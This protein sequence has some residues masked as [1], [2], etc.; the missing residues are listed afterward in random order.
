MTRTPVIVGVGQ[1]SEQLD[2]DRYL[3]LSPVDLAAAA[4]R[5]ALA[6]TGVSPGRVAE[7]IDTVA[8][9][10]QFEISLPGAPVLL[11]RSDNFPRSVA[12]RLGADPRRA[13]LEVV[14]GQAPQKLV[15]E[16]AREIA[17]GTT[18]VALVFGSEAISTAEHFAK[19]PEDRRP[20]WT[21]HAEGSLED[22]GPGLE[23]L[24]SMPLVV[25]GLYDTISQYALFENAR[26]ARLKLTRQEY[27]ESMGRLF[28][29]FTE[30]ASRNP[31]SAAPQR[32]GAAELVTPSARNR[33]IADPYTKFVVARE[34][35]NQAAAV[36]VMSTEKACEL[37][38]P[39]EKWVYPAGHADL[40]EREVLDRPDLSASPAT[41]AAIGHALEVAGVSPSEVTWFDL[42]SCYPIAV[43]VAA[44]ALGVERDLTLTGGLPFF[45]G[46]GNNYSMHGIAEVVERTRREPGSY[47]FVGAN[48]GLLS[49]YSAGVYTTTPTPWRADRSA[50]LQRAL[51]AGP[52]TEVTEKPDGPATIETWTVKHGRDGARTGIV[53]GRLDD[54]GRRF[55]ARAA[56]DEA[57]ALLE[58]EEPVG[59]RVVV[60]S[61]EDGNLFAV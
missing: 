18:E 36:L 10:R 48:G 5:E 22:R 52:G 7:V 38:I 42:Y 44:E 19:Q 31:H 45:G 50:E 1:A 28:E 53:V 12:G 61:G 4:A 41:A 34:K 39:E 58:T 6:D 32:R 20:D 16:L 57:L 13:I 21:E 24:I 17:A 8:G 2:D 25:H 30:V 54:D 15:T 23:G 60:R 27:A 55:V 37:G 49:K 59:A 9:V 33:I 11:G 26:R 47:G 29:P 40:R 46:A 35:V 51:D 14:G 56:D 43:F 3:A